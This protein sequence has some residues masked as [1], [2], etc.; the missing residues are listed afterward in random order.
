MQ[1]AAIL[2]IAF[3]AATEKLSKQAAAVSEGDNSAYG[4]LLC[5]SLRLGDDPVAFEPKLADAPKPPLEL[6][7]LNMSLAEPSWRKLFAPEENGSQKKPK[8][9]PA[10]NI[11]TEWQDKWTV[12]A[13]A[14]K[15]LT[16]DN[17]EKAL[18]ERLGLGD[19]S[20]AAQ[21]QIRPIIA[22]Y[23]KAAFEIYKAFRAANPKAADDDKKLKDELLTTL[24]GN[25]DGYTNNGEENKLYVGTKGGYNAVCGGGSSKDPT[26]TVAA[27]FACVC[28][29]DNGKGSVHPCHKETAD[30]PKWESGGAPTPDNWKKVRKACPVIQNSPVTAA[31]IEQALAAAANS[32][33]VHN[34]NAYIGADKAATC[35]GNGNEACVKIA[36]AATDDKLTTT[37]V[38][39]I[40]KISAIATKLRTRADY[41]HQATVT[42]GK[43]TQLTAL[44]EAQAKLSKLIRSI[45]TPTTGVT[46]SEA[47]KAQKNRETIQTAAACKQAKPTC[48]W[49]GSDDKDGPHCELNTTAVEKRETQTK[50]RV[51]NKKEEKCAG[52]EDKDCKSPDCKW[53]GETCKYS[54]FL[55]NKKFALMIEFVSLVVFK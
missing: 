6:Y 30:E 47:K 55:V 21:A 38:Q 3:F 40:G 9:Q 13:D 4:S 28:G 53:E 14:E 24:Y 51:E 26:L 27:T 31:R 34:T 8:P 35:N 42:S 20:E 46:N 5:G 11:P 22:A 39:W 29:V 7:K 45:P 25:T 12:W 10:T 43:L 19:I 50:A 17:E 54:S 52:K 15:T 23:A 32:I 41:N 16:A 36:T 1:K 33:T 18:K 48:E 44:A 37:K 49:K 2:A